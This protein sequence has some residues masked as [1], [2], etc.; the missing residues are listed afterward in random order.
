MLAGR[1]ATRSARVAAPRF[2]Y[3]PVRGFAEA[4]PAADTKPPVQVFGLDGTYA[5]A[6]VC[7]PLP[8]AFLSETLF[9]NTSTR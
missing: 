9:T 2:S 8:C 6:L 7:L 4:K 3:A 5:S 1:I